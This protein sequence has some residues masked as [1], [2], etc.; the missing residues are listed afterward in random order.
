MQRELFLV[1]LIVAA[2]S[3]LQIIHVSGSPNSIQ[4]PVKGSLRGGTL[5][6]IKALGH[7]P[8]PS[9]NQIYVGNFPCVVPADGVTDTFITCETVDTGSTSEIGNM[10]VSLTYNG[11]TVTTKYPDTVYFRTYETPELR[12]VFPSTGFAGSSVNFLGVHEISD[13]GDGLRALGDVV[14]LR[15]G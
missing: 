8:D 12:E 6:Y 2:Q 14:G 5:V 10:P 7:S 11:I 9:Q 15:L 1:V 3:Q 4:R 13:L